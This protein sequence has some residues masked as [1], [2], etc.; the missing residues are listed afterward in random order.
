MVHGRS[1]R[2]RNV[3]PALIV[4]VLLASVLAPPVVGPAAAQEVL[5]NEAVVSMVKAGL[6][7]SVIIAKIRSSPTKF[8]LRT[9]ALV[10]LKQAG[11]SDK[12]LEAM[13]TPA[14][15][16][17]TAAV[18]KDRDVMYHVVGDRLVELTPAV[19][20]I[21]TNMAFFT[22]KSELV[23][24]GRRAPYR[25]GERQPVFLSSYAPTEALLVRLEPGD[26]HDDRNLKIGSGAFHPF[27]GTLRTGVRNE[28]R[29]EVESER[30]ARGLYRVRPRKPLAPGEYGFVLIHGFASG[31]TG[32]VYDF[33]VE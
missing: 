7:D 21:Q 31:T 25:T 12:V 4:L 15:P 26:D 22:Q 5:T 29:I 3:T 11:V 18:L 10:A 2:A 24:R 9:D 1:S 20:E 33:G 14:A 13:V 6:P 17:A 27:G 32:K 8:D 28:D 19:G 30:D 23:L 16:P